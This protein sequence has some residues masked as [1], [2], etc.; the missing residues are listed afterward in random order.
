MRAGNNLH[1]HSAQSHWRRNEGHTHVS[2]GDS[3]ADNSFF[4]IDEHVRRIRRLVE[5]AH[6]RKSETERRWSAYLIDLDAKVDPSVAA[7]A[8]QLWYNLKDQANRL[9][10]PDASPTSDGGFI[11]SWSAGGRY[12]EIEVLNDGTYE[13]LY[14]ERATGV[15]EFGS[16]STVDV[17][18]DSALVRRLVGVAS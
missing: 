1:A 17:R 4:D 10:P 3:Y 12:L 9:A 18:L 16:P 14:R 11:M 7:T 8:E 13:W 5:A 15:A 6:S 2:P